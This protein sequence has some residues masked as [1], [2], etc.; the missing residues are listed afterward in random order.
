MVQHFV[1]HHHCHC[2]DFVRRGGGILL[3]EDLGWSQ[4]KV[5]RRSSA[6]QSVVFLPEK[7]VCKRLLPL[8]A[9]MNVFVALKRGPFKKDMN[10][11]PTINFSRD[12]WVLG[13]VK[14]KTPTCVNTFIL[15]KTLARVNCAMSPV[16]LVS[17]LNLGRGVEININII[18]F[19]RN[20]DWPQSH[21]SLTAQ[22]KWFSEFIEFRLLWCKRRKYK[23]IYICICQ[24]I[25]T[26]ICQHI[27][28]Y[29]YIYIYIYRLKYI[30]IYVHN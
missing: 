29:I 27:Y 18:H 23:Y 5:L 22:L 21:K 19:P 7:F 26:Y 30:Y 10:H 28:T 17:I 9:K 12:I 15:A 20:P 8:A 4:G 6:S 3:E 16:D 24:H 11:L 13:G 1:G 14:R 2:L 25:Y